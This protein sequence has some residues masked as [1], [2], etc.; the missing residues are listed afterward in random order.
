MDEQPN[1]CLIG[2]D[3]GGTTCRV[4]LVWAG[5]RHEVRLGPANA[6]TDRA[7]AIATVRAGIRQVTALA[8]IGAGQPV[9]THVALAGIMSAADERAVAR[10]LGLDHVTA[11][12]T[13]HVTVS[14]DQ[15]S[16]VAGALSGA[17]GAVAGIGT[18]SF[19]ARRSG[20]R[21][22]FVGGWGLELGDE[23]S[24]AWLGRGLLA[25]TLHVADGLMPGTDLTETIRARFG[26]AP[27][28]VAFAARA[29]PGDFAE[30]AP[31][32]VAAA[33]DGDGVAQGL[34]RDGAGY[35]GRGLAALGRNAGE[36]VCLS[37]GLGPAY[38]PWLADEL[39]ASLCPP[40]G[41]ALDGA[42]WLAGQ[43]MSEPGAS[44]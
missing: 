29:G 3:G 5:R 44:G 24:G 19:L 40:R 7:G 10:G 9:R 20:G 11:H 30:L 26:T 27:D 16:T 2:V 15:V 33:A 39:R 6:R 22:A 42:L 41:S 31:L 4:A 17:D 25:A 38:A 12:V 21:L 23:A 34:M 14:D 18:G 43:G 13:A 8:R 35:I 36:P 37:G 32:I 1:T 28:I